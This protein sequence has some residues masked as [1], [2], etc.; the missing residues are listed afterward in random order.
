[1]NATT[2]I[3][4]NNTIQLAPHETMELHEILHNEVTAAKK[5][6]ATMAVVGDPELRRFMELALNTKHQILENYSS[7]YMGTVHK[8]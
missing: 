4:T 2:T 1:M 3:N 5:I 6:Q 7:F 8:Q